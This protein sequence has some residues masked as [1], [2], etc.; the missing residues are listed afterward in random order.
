ML[1]A[2]PEL[3]DENFLPLNGFEIEANEPKD[4]GKKVR[5]CCHLCFIAMDPDNQ[6]M[7]FYHRTKYLFG[8]APNYRDQLQYDESQPDYERVYHPD[9]VNEMIAMGKKNGF[10]VTYNH[11]IWSLEDHGDYMAYDGMD[12]M[13]IYNHSSAS[14]GFPEYNAI[15][16]DEMLRGGKRLFCVSADD[17]HNRQSET[18][19]KWDSFG[20]FVMIKADRLDYKTITAALREGHF[21]ASQGP[22]IHDLYI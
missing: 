13:E 11:P 21:Y 22:R 18:S 3:A 20:G 4:C 19:G 17:N 2:H 12:A 7:P 16:Y 10:F 6:K 9:C 14:A 1:I 5:K 8:N 15:V